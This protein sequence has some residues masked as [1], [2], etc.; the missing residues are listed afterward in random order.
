MK[1]GALIRSAKIIKD[2][3]SSIIETFSDMFPHA[4]ALLAS[5][6]LMSYIIYDV[7]KNKIAE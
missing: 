6:V 2:E 5:T 7:T 1:L 3:L 4:N